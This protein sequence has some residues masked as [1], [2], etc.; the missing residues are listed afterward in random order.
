MQLFGSVVVMSAVFYLCSL[1]DL[2]CFNADTLYICLTCSVSNQL[3]ILQLS[4]LFG[5]PVVCDRHMHL[6]VNFA[7][8]ILSLIRL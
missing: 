2:M 4:W 6:P 7:A 3:L 8:C 5:L 1:S